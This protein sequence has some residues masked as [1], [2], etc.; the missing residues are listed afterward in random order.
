MTPTDAIST[1]RHAPRH[2]ASPVRT[3]PN[4][5]KWIALAVAAALVLGAA[6]IA[7]GSERS[8]RAAAETKGLGAGASRG[9]SE[10]PAMA[11]TTAPTVPTATVQ[12][13]PTAPATITIVAVGDLLFDSRPRRM[14]DAKGPAAPLAKVASRLSRADLTIAN[15]ESTLSN[16]GAPVLGKP[17]SLIFNGNPKGALTLASAGI[18]VVSNANNHAMDH[19]R[20]ALADTIAAL[21]KAGI[22]HAGAGMN[23]TQAWAPAYLVVKGR[24]IAYIAATQ[25]VP[26]YFLPSATRAGVAN[27]HDMKRLVATVKAARKKADIVIVSVHWGI[28]RSYTANAGQKHDARALIDAGA[29]LVLSH[30]PHVLQGIDTYKGKLIAYSL[31]NFLFPYKSASGRES[32][33]LG[34]EY[35]RKGVANITAVPVYLGAWGEP[36]VQTGARARTILGRLAAASKPMGTKVT[37]KNNIGYIRP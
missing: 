35:G 8:L 14:I 22:K 4:A 32:F 13:S 15:L 29:D 11:A 34:F 9:V 21:D 3:L 31:G 24:R 19:G 33:I 6:A 10:P 1:A 2:S 18:D 30:H 5:T 28:E 7:V 20:I 16:R 25:I 17:A 12:P 27:G 23:T 37:I 36:I 26:S